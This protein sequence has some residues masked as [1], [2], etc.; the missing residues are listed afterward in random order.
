MACVLYIQNQEIVN[1]VFKFKLNLPFYS[2]G[3]VGIYNIGIIGAAFILGVFFTLV[4]GALRATG[5]SGEIKTR[6][7]KIKELESEIAFLEKKNRESEMSA[8]TTAPSPP[9]EK[10]PEAA[11]DPF[12]ASN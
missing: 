11:P 1:H 4:V 2:Y 6:N 12:S 10:Q 8:Q 3:P 5:K 9:N 7:K